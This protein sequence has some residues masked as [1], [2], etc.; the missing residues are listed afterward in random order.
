VLLKF[1]FTVVHAVML[2]YTLGYTIPLSILIQSESCDLM[3]VHQEARV[4][5]FNFSG[6]I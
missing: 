5:V 3:K 6:H 1:E 4:L 2:Q